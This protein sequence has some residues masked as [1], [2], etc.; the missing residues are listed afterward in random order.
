MDPAAPPYSLPP[1]ALLAPQATVIC[2]PMTMNNRTKRPLLTAAA[3]AAVVMLAACGSVRERLPDLGR[4]ASTPAVA[5]SPKTFAFAQ[6]VSDLKPDPAI[7]FGK[8][9]NG[10]RYAIRHNATPPGQAS[11]RLRID[12]GS[13]M[14]TDDQRGLAHFLEHM[15]FNGSKTVPEGE[16]VK[17]LER[18]GLAFGAD[19]NA[20]TSYDETIYRLDLP[21]TDNETVDTAL[22]LLR[23]VGG[24]LTLSQTSIERERGVVLS[25]ERARDTPRYHV[26]EQRFGFLLKGQ[27]PP[28]RQPIGAVEVIRGA[29]RDRL[30]AFYEAYY[31]PERA[32]LVA[33]GDFDVDALEAKIKAVYGGWTN[34]AQDGPE[35]D[36]GP[37][38]KR[39]P[40]AKVLVQPGASTSVQVAWMNPPDKS[41]DTVAN[42]RRLLVRNL[43][44]QVLNRR[45]S[46][47]ARAAEPPFISAGASRGDQV[48][49]AEIATLA[50]TAR[51]GEW[52]AALVALDVEQRRAI[53]YGLRQDE[54]DREI[55]EYRSSL[56]AA[57]A[58][59][60]T[61]R[62]PAVAADILG[63]VADDEVVTNPDQE[64]AFYE[65]VAKDLKAAEVSAALT[66]ALSGEGPLI[67]V[68]SP[69][70]VPGGERA[71]LDA[72][73]RAHRLE[74]TRPVA[75]LSGV[76][77]YGN[78]GAVG[79]VAERTEITDL[80][81]VFVRFENGVCLTVKPTKFRTEQIYVVARVGEGLASLPSDKQTPGWASSAFIEGGLKKVTADEMEGI[82]AAKRFG[83]S[84]GI[85]DNA[86][87][88]TGGTRPEDLAT[89]LQVLAA[90]VAEP[91]WRP[92]AFERVRNYG[93][94]LHDQLEGT[95]NGVL[96]RDLSG[97]LH[98]G[99][100]RWTFPSR[101]EMAATTLSDLK[102]VIDPALSSGSIEIVIVGDTTVDKA[103]DA[104]ATTF[105]ALPP[106]PAP[107]RLD[108]PVGAVRF[109]APVAAPLVLTHNGRADQAIA[110]MAWPAEDFYVDTRRA[111]ATGVMSDVLKLRLVDELREKQGATYSPSVGYVA[112]QV[113]PGYG[114]LAASEE[115]PP[116]ML[117]GFF[118]DVAKIAGNLR[119]QPIGVDEL[120]RA[121]KPRIEALER[122]RETNE[123]WLDQ[124]SGA[125]ADPRRLDAIRSAVASLESVGPA[126]VQAAAARYL[127]DDKAWKLVIKPK[128]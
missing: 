49:A 79:K 74:P 12:A 51:P 88:L 127:R 64:L 108:P 106:R 44:L 124:L 48:K 35:F 93:A 39:G 1:A 120:D 83:V 69:T 92:E 126:E 3:L 72:Y 76:W 98:A 47:R 109:P 38:A 77:P 61:R 45:F 16:M 121:K 90:H 6:E 89:Q 52:E 13:L 7:R 87:E 25:E 107:K 53:R 37:V 40:E 15:A 43:G 70:A 26:F 94:T 82:L 50:A 42:R 118:R 24:E 99:D 41:L 125:Q 17:I 65:S 110:Y 73:A 78:F 46:A 116:A 34:A 113:W 91:G 66:G 119:D 4:G 75:P 2:P 105:G 123:Y 21:R 22:R 56:E 71:V 128:G 11:L 55:V 63:T 80:D 32:F 30:A 59:A 95:D 101:A 85:D 115:A 36:P 102:S 54:L 103:I 20:S 31:R 117:D 68:A 84:F 111:R 86:F 100:R 81:T 19:T 96:R 29:N 60:K 62:T 57:A 112:S 58:G 67:F 33:V 18:L 104:V 8:L 122:S 28:T 23:D 9:P 14:E 5:A 114:Y 97:L 10:M 27:R